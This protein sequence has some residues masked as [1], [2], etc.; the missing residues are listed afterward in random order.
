[1]LD[2]LDEGLDRERRFVADASHELRTP[3]ALLLTEVELA[4]SGPRSP[5]DLVDALRSPEEEVRRLIALS[6]DLL[7]LAGAVDGGSSCRPSRS[8]SQRSP[9]RS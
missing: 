4:L 3:L 7:A 1:M 9:A 8:T 5:E 2:R 6:E